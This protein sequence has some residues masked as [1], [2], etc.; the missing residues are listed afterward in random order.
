MTTSSNDIS[1]VLSGGSSNIDPNASLG[2]DPSSTP[3][4]VATLNNLF[5]DLSSDETEDGAVDYRCLYVFNDGDTVVYNVNL[6][7]LDE[8]IGGSQIEIGVE[9]KNESQRITLSGGNITSGNAVLSYEGTSFQITYNSDLSEWAGQI[10]ETLAELAD[11]DDELYFNEVTVIA[12]TGAN[13]TI[14]FDISFS[15]LDAKRN[16]AKIERVSNNFIGTGTIEVTITVP[17]EGSP[18]NTIAPELNAETTPPGG[19]IVFYPATQDV[20]ISLPRLDPG[21]GFPIW[22]KRSTAA[23]TLAIEGDGFTLRLTAQ[24]K[25]SEV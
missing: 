3:V 8:V 10:E 13:S 12:Q 25:P 19:S 5:D 14:I 11:D 17:T 15:G 6:W 16:I 20:P 18:I 23:G 4:N 1:I 9:T 24:S 2:G 7:L 22:I 21:D